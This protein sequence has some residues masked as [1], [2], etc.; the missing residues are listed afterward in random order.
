MKIELIGSTNNLKELENMKKFSYRNGR[1]C[2]TEKDWEEVQKELVK[3]E[4]LGSM[5]NSGHHSIFEHVNLGLYLDGVK[6]ILAMVLNNE[7]Q[8]ATSEK[9]ARYTKMSDI[10]PLQNEKYEKWMSILIPEIDKVYPT[11]NNSEKRKIAIQKLAKEN[12]RYM[13][14]VFTPTKMTHTINLRQLN[15]IVN[16]FEKYYAAHNNSEDDFKRRISQEMKE[17]ASQTERFKIAGLQNQ[18]D[19][20]LSLFNSRDVETH[21]GDVYSTQHFS[22][23][24]SLAQE[25]RHRTID[26]NIIKG[27]ELDAPQGFFIPKIIR[28][29]NQLDGEWIKDLKKIA[30]TD[31]PQAQLLKVGERGIIEDFRSKCFLRMCGHAMYE[32]MK[33]TS[34]TA[35]RYTQ[36]QEEFGKNAL[37]P[38]C[39]QGIKCQSPCV[40]KGKKA[41]ERIV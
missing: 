22:S 16:E 8:Y 14:S 15:F 2:Y 17:F 10:D 13:T 7:K 1:I 29:N 23:F 18:T 40:W 27:L 39:L 12:A 20:R 34:E 11:L 25:H 9:S 19:R 32:T 24:A 31:Y 41:L 21:F 28:E 33:N 26:Y 3:K 5:L 37:K 36:Y 38:K 35:R 4:L 30:R 6:K